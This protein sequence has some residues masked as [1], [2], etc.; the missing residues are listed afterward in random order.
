MM[1]FPSVKSVESVVEH[2]LR[3][4]MALFQNRFAAVT[5]PPL[6]CKSGLEMVKQTAASGVA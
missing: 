3:F 5:R 2:Q 6:Q 1:N 4:V